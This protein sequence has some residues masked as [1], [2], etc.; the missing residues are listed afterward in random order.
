MCRHLQNKEQRKCINITFRLRQKR[1][2]FALFIVEVVGFTKTLSRKLKKPEGLLSPKQNSEKIKILL[3]SRTLLKWQYHTS[4]NPCPHQQINQ[5]HLS[6]FAHAQLVD[7][8]K[9]INLLFID[10]RKT[11]RRFSKKTPFK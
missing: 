11:M 6:L 2:K 8:K 7:D 10:S 9:V 5:I 3:L 4:L 1:E